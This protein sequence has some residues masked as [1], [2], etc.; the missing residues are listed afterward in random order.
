MDDLCCHHLFEVIA[1]RLG[2]LGQILACQLESDM[3]MNVLYRSSSEMAKR[4]YQCQLF[5][6]LSLIL[7]SQVSL[8][9]RAILVRVK[10]QKCPVLRAALFCIASV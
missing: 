1:S 10:R 5:D 4:S 9:L 8:Q 7:A 6:T 3:M 2:R